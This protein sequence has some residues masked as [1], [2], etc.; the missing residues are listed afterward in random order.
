MR[1]LLAAGAVSLCLTGT[2]FGQM[3]G[4]HAQH[5]QTTQAGMGCMGQM[6]Q[7]QQSQAT[8]PFGQPQA[9]SAAIMCACCRN[10]AMIQGP[11]QDSA[12]SH[13]HQHQ[14]APKQQ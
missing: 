3:C 4:G 11:K 14:E 8:D 13:D 7:A 12:P 2:A 9:K 5:G 6:Q 1:T 10:M